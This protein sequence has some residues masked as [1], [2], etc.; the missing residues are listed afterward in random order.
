MKNKSRIYFRK[1]LLVCK[2]CQDSF[3]TERKTVDTFLMEI[4]LIQK[5]IFLT[6]KI[7]RRCV[8]KLSG[9]ISGYVF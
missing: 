2:R 6:I 5:C 3:Y 9:I 7:R 4:G 8:L 1:L